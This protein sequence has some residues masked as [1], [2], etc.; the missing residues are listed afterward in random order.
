MILKNIYNSFF[1][2]YKTPFGAVRV[3]ETVTF[4]LCFPTYLKIAEP[5]LAVFK[6]GS[7]CEYINFEFEANESP[8]DV[9]D[10]FEPNLPV[11]IAATVT[12]EK[13][14]I[15]KENPKNNANTGSA[16][17]IYKC[18]YSPDTSGIYEYCFSVLKDGTKTEIKRKGASIGAY[19]GTELFQLTVFAA[20]YNTPDWLKGG[21]MY[22]IF[23]DRFAKYIP[24]GDED[25]SPTACPS[26]RIVHITWND[27]PKWY[28]D[29][30]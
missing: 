14:D 22:Q 27:T 7:K 29:P 8:N 11:P 16:F 19:D 28:P 10:V 20:D 3:G 17:A 9:L 15:A 26:D 24:S 23:P 12:K 25:Y 4:R 21:V 13:K 1:A 2:E 30:D 6:P 18:E 5:S